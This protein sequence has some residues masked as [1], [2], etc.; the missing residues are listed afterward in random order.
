MKKINDIKIVGKYRFTKW[1]VKLI[2]FLL[3]IILVTLVFAL[4]RS[5][6][7]NGNSGAKDI[8]GKRLFSGSGTEDSDYVAFEDDD[9]L[10]G[11]R[12]KDG[13][14][15]LEPQ[16]SNIY[17]LNS[18]KF[19]VEKKTD[20]KK[21]MGI[22]DSNENCTVPF[23]FEKFI[24]EGKNFLLGL[25]KDSGEIILMDSSGNIV[26]DRAWKK[27]SYDSSKDVI[28]MSSEDAEYSYDCS[29]SRI[30]CKKVG[31]TKKSAGCT[32]L[33]KTDDKAFIGSITADKIEKI[34]TD[35]CVYF[36]CVFSGNLDGI[37]QITSKKYFESLSENEVFK[38]C[39]PVKIESISIG[40]SDGEGED[41]TLSAE[42]LYN[43]SDGEK[44]IEELKSLVTLS[45]V[46]G[47]DASLV[48]K[49]IN[50]EEL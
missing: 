42:I 23:I 46:S 5:F 4:F 44:T 43:Y 39:A 38:N 18:G 12:D 24:T 2:V 9:G 27:Y 25:V 7:G 11:V 13:N 41:Y 8:T 1:Y 30:S 45:F 3:F 36:D 50:K 19:A 14:N 21:V 37:L 10:Y 6:L 35:S 47:T 22:V 49:S 26:S 15:V 40:L 28:S 29:D 17:F 32:V 33:Y 34:L 16:W 48:L 31:F 20:E